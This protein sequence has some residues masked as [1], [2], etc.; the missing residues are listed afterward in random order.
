MVLLSPP[1]TP[2]AD[3]GRKASNGQP[4]PVGDGAKRSAASKHTLLEHCGVEASQPL[5]RHTRQRRRGTSQNLGAGET[6]QS[7]S[8]ARQP[9]RCHIVPPFAV[10]RL[11]QY[12]VARVNL[13]QQSEHALEK[14]LTVAL[15]T[16]TESRGRGDEPIR[17][18]SRSQPSLCIGQPYLVDDDAVVDSLG[19]ASTDEES[20]KSFT[21]HIHLFDTKLPEIALVHL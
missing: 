7:S 8:Q 2:F 4:N 12:R 20:T 13:I 3:P 5:T 11:V 18:H 16:K 10:V 9:G 1:I 14:R 17:L 19:T 6:T 15:T 21:R